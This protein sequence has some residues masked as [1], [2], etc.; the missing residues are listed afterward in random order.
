MNAPRRVRLST[1]LRL[2]LAPLVVW[3]LYCLRANVW[4]RLYPAVI[5]VLALGAFAWTLLPGRMPL[6]ECFARRMGEQLD[7]RGVAYCRRVTEV[8]TAF[9]LVHLGVTIATV[10]LSREIWVFYNGFLAYV[11][12]GALFVGEWLVRRRVR[13]GR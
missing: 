10:F 13:H 8:W 4:F 12:M 1:V 5:V 3:G 2:T 7:A 9:L 6:V 11:L